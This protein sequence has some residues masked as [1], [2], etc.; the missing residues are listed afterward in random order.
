MSTNGDKPRAKRRRTVKQ[1]LVPLLM[2]GSDGEAYA[3]APSQRLP[4]GLLQAPDVFV[5]VRLTH[6]ERSL[7]LDALQ[8]GVKEASRLL[9]D[10]LDRKFDS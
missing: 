10:V 4:P 7:A 3:C 5:A 9:V 8:V 2:L 1:P 6:H